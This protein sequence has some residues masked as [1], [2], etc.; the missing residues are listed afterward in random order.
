MFEIIIIFG[1]S[2]LLIHSYHTATQYLDMHRFQTN[3]KNKSTIEMDLTRI[4][5]TLRSESVIHS[6][7]VGRSIPRGQ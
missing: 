2:L 4:R 5:N 3:R 6:I 7:I 1:L